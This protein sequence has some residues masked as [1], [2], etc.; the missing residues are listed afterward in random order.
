MQQ[1][2]LIGDSIRMG[3]QADVIRELSGLADVWAPTQNGGN[4]EN[5]LQHLDEWIISR[6]PDVVHIN[7]GLHDLRKDFDT[8]EPAISINQYESNLRALLERI[9]AETNC[10]VIWAMTTPVNEIWH[11]ERKGFDRLEADVGA[12]NAIACKVADDLDIPI[13]DLFGVITDA[14]RDSYLTPDGVHFTP[15]GSALL[16]KAVA[17]FVKPYLTTPQD[18]RA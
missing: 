15:E 13:N 12:Y 1:L 2:I 18:N 3:Y 4:S 6:S 14:G 10:T 7:C 5:I 8:G 16:G 11:H 17:E 9:L